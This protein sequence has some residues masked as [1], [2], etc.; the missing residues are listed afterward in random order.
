MKVRVSPPDQVSRTARAALMAGIEVAA[1]AAS[2]VGMAPV[3]AASIAIFAP[4]LEAKVFR[5]M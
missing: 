2:G 1:I 5:G 3:R 4:F